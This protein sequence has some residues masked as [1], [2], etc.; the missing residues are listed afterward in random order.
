MRPAPR[1]AVGRSRAGPRS[2]SRV[3]LVEAER[4]ALRKGLRFE[5]ALER[6]AQAVARLPLPTRRQVVRALL[7]ESLHRRLAARRPSATVH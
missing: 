1:R 4:L 2:A 5:A 3:L 7:R 6:V